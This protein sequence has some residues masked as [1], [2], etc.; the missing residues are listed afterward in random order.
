M[1]IKKPDWK[2]IKIWLKAN[3]KYILWCI[4]FA[5]VVG[6]LWW[7]LPTLPS[8]WDA[9]W[10]AYKLP[11]E[12]IRNFGLI[13]AAAFGIRIAS[14]RAKTADKQTDISNR[15]AEIAEKGH[16]TDRFSKAVELLGH[17]KSSIQ[18]G[19]IFTLEKIAREDPA[20]YFETVY[21]LLCAFIRDHAPLI[22]DEEPSEDKKPAEK[23]DD[24]HKKEEL[25]KKKELP[26]I[27]LAVQTAL[28]V[29]GRREGDVTLDLHETNLRRADLQGAD[30][31]EANLQGADLQG[32]DL[33]G[34]DLVGANLQGADLQGANLLSTSLMRANLI[35]ADLRKADLQDANLQGVFLQVAFLQGVILQGVNLQGVN[36]QGVNLQGADLSGS[37]FTN[38]KNLTQE[39]VSSGYIQSGCPVTGLPSGWEQPPIR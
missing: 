18:V 24:D 14:W 26:P 35:R 22:P 38:T 9:I 19:G 13:V 4:G 5:G 21:E 7:W 1:Q 6:F 28:T 11:S 39:Q 8:T 23:G 30:L 27:T 37:N 32:A 17:D 2:T 33:Q 36:L 12:V 3:L 15:Q 29:I 10:K 25:A 20:T 16:L 31:V 34:A